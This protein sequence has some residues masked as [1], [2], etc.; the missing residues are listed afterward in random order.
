MSLSSERAD[1]LRDQATNAR[2]GDLVL[3]DYGSS[4]SHPA[5]A[6]LD[7]SVGPWA[8]H[9]VGVDAA[10]SG[11]AC[12]HPEFPGS[13]DLWYEV[14]CRSCVLALGALAHQSP[15]RM[16]ENPGVDPALR[17][18]AAASYESVRSEHCLPVLGVSS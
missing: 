11:W 9:A 5:R 12:E 10:L 14:R 1:I 4:T 16:M 8:F 17:L 6:L 2:F 15:Q 7:P 18:T 3:R 13:A